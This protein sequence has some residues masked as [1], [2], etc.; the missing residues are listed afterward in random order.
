[1]RVRILRS[2]ASAE[3]SYGYGQEV[4]VGKEFTADTIPADVAE[5]WLES[6]LA[7]AVKA[8]PESAAVEAPEKAVKPRPKKRK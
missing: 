5:S 4:G 2:I 6:G 1:M 8:K 7:E 3:W